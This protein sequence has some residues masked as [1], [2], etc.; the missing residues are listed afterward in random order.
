[1]DIRYKAH[2]LHWDQPEKFRELDPH[3]SNLSQLPLIYRF[4]LLDSLPRETP[5]IYSITGG[6]QVG[7][8]TLLKQ[9]MSD[10]LHSGVSPRNIAYLPGEMIDDHHGLVHL[11][12]E[13]IESV[14][15]ETKPLFFLLD[16]VTYINQWDRGIK[17]LADAG[18]LRNTILVL[19]GSDTVVIRDARAR[20][21]GR[22]GRADRVDFHLFPLS[23]AEYVS[24]GKE[25]S[26][27]EVRQ[28]SE[29]STSP[30]VLAELEQLFES[31]LAHGGYLTAINDLKRYGTINRATFVTYA[32]WIRGDV[33]KR[34]KR[35]HY[36][37]EILTAIAKRM[38]SQVTWNKLSGDLSI[39]HPAT[40]ADYVELLSRMDA[41][42]IQRALREDKLTGSPKKAR[43][44]HFTDPFIFH[45]VRSWLNNT[46]NPYQQEVQPFLA[47]AE[48]RGVLVESCAV[49]HFNRFYPTYYIKGAGEVDI[50]YVR[51][52]R[53]WPVEVKWTR[54]LRAADF[55]QAS[56]YPDSI[57]CSRADQPPQVHGITC[58]P[59]VT[60]LLRL[61]PSPIYL[62][63]S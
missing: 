36:L 23:F 46:E 2:N 50:A 12:S 6:R 31:Y 32:D 58:R 9:Y 43:K 42:I 45:A 63:E 49:S 60:T 26:H 59:L 3:L 47:D 14:G 17:Y 13:F 30:Q 51:D 62:P 7:K 48:K 16:E 39:N 37:R 34:G 53:F 10:L 21:P 61:G 56:K 11:F 38:G 27:D 1:M 29:S 33:L 18:L 5:G 4:P 55:K 25:I 40:V 8:T 15:P 57:I 44:L 41:A 19:T 52:N 54:Q 28:I 22:R 20:F 35:E 24:L